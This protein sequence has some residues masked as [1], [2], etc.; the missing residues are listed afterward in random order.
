[1]PLN[2]RAAEL[3]AQ[4]NRAVPESPGVYTWLGAAGEPLYVGKSRNLRRRMLS[5]LT[6]RHAAPDARMRHLT[7]AIDAFQWRPTSGE[8]LALLLEDALIKQVLPRH[9]VQQRDYGER[10][11]L[12][13]TGDAFPAVVVAESAR[14]PGALFGP[15]KDQY[16]VAD[17]A[18][19]VGEWFGLRSCQDP[20]P[21][22]RSARFDLGRCPGPCRDAVSVG[23]YASSVAAATAFLDGEGAWISQRLSAAMEVAAEQ[24]LLGVMA[25]PKLASDP[26]FE[27][28][29]DRMAHHQELDALV[30]AWTAQHGDYQLMH[31]LQGCGIPAPVLEAS[32]V[33]DDPQ[34]KARHFWKPLPIENGETYDFIG[35]LWQFSDTPVPFAAGPT[36]IGEYNDYVYRE[37]LRVDDDEY[38]RL[39]AAGHITMDLDESVP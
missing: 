24:S 38:N 17:L 2:D 36:A 25:T 26:R 19:F 1:M 28:N 3:R 4:I 7:Y 6:P 32:R 15:F 11:Y 5:Y 35:P 18:E 22:R 21:F 29:V 23:D 13:L 27:T 33:L 9:N 31:L 16:F 34:L 14:R 37:V 30:T 39:K 12:L 20:V 8:L 10:R